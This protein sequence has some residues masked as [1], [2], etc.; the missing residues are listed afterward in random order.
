MRRVYRKDCVCPA[1]WTASVAGCLPDLAAFQQQAV[2]FEALDLNSA[3]RRDG[4]PAYAPG[5]LLK[6]KSGK[7]EFPPIWG[8]HKE[9]IAAMSHDKCVYCE[10]P[11]NALGAQHVEHFR[12][13]ALF[14]SLAYEWTNYFVGCAGCNRAKSDKW[15]KRGAYVQPDRGDPSR[16]FVFDE[17]GT[18]SAVRVGS[19]ADEM[20]QDLDLK[21]RAVSRQRKLLIEFMLKRVR[22]AAQLYQDGNVEAATRL[23]KEIL[24]E[25]TDPR[26]AYSTAQT[27][28]F[29]RAWTA[30]CP[31]VRVYT[32]R[33]GLPKA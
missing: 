33:R 11:I 17:D 4:F 27:Q 19:V 20:L 32:R 12:P 25:V 9:A 13:K 18:V 10:G 2:A 30:S 7:L 28:C 3:T 5:V 26:I 6:K 15:P 23:A 8:K 29:L 21:R 1:T 14:P 31:G 24:D 16:H 22:T